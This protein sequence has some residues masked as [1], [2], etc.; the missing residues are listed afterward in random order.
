MM[1]PT[2]LLRDT[3]LVG[4]AL[5][6]IAWF[7]GA[8]NA[9]FVAVGAGA[10]LLNLAVLVLAA[11]GVVRGGIGAALMPM[12]LLLAVGLVGALTAFF[13]P[14]PVLVGFGA[15]P[16]GVVLSGLIGARRLSTA[17]YP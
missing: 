4:I 6:A 15:G 16:L 1:P 12:K 10:A 17:E 11:S 9:M 7:W 14:V 13:P 3:A 5:T 8:E 2:H